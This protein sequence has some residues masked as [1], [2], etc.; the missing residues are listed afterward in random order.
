[1]AEVPL[2]EEV[3][4][5]WYTQGGK[6]TYDAYQSEPLE[7][8]ERHLNA[9]FNKQLAYFE[10]ED[11]NLYVHA[12]YDPGRPITEQ[13][14]YDLIWTRE[15]WRRQLTA[16]AYHECFIGHTPTWS[17]SM[18][19]CRRNNVWNLDQGA[20]YSGK[21]SLMNAR[22]KEYVQSDVVQ[23]LYPGVKGR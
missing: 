18:V 19:P 12:G 9:F 22:T 21:L 14:A 5:S 6:A 17:T 11:N 1:L 20:A 8:R 3:Y 13:D 10:D 23:K 4:R 2:P 16:S 15:L 7:L